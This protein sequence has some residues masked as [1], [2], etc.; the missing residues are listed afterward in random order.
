[1]KTLDEIHSFWLNP[2][3][4][5]LPETYVSGERSKLLLEIFKELDVSTRSSILE[6]GC[7]VGRNLNILYDNGYKNLKGIEIN[8]NAKTIMETFFPSI[9][10]EAY[11]YWG[12]IESAD[13]PES[14]VIFTMAVLEHIHPDSE[15]IFDVVSK[16]SNKYII[17]IEDER[18]TSDRHF[19]RNYKSVFEPLGFKQVY[20]RNCIGVFELG[21]DFFARAFVKL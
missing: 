5:N 17:T 8:Y 11:I 2:N 13:I 9:Y 21:A 12:S 1:M 3:D 6:L 14:D 20:E 15:W 19:V 7:N 18:V 4:Q 10:N 16:R